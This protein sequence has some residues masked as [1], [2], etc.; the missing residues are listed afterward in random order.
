MSP[1]AQILADDV[2]SLSPHYPPE[3]SGSS[4][5]IVG[6]FLLLFLAGGLG[7]P[8]GIAAI[9]IGYFLK[10]NLHLSP[11]E[12]ALFVAIAGV[13]AYFGF[14]PGF[15][16]DRFRPQVMGDRA[17]LLIG[18]IFALAAYLF[19][20]MASIGYSTLLYATLIAGI[21]YLIIITAAQAM[22]TGVAQ[23]HL[24]TGRLSVVAGV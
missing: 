2:R 12:L 1:E 7:A 23:A 13:P 16:R 3:S 19:L 22:M 20:G 18:A 21:A 5:G 14:L 8:T 11:V 24:M 6:Y 17:Y 15:I 10:D 4:T 9:P